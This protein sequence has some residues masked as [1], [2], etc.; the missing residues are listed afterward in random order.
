[1]KQ[2]DCDLIVS[3]TQR[4]KDRRR[5]L[6]IESLKTI[7]RSGLPHETILTLTMVLEMKWLFAK[8]QVLNRYLSLS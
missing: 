8:C 1:M 5:R 4:N 6:R 7:L 2:S 3:N